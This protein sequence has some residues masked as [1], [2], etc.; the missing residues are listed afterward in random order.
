MKAASL[1]ILIIPILVL[2]CGHNQNI[3]PA[4]N[5]VLTEYQLYKMH[6]ETR[7]TRFIYS[8]GDIKEGLLLRWQGDSIFIQPRSYGST[9]YVPSRGLTA[10]RCEVGNR[11]YLGAAIGLLAGG[12]YFI[13]VEGWDF[14]STNSGKVLAK[15]LVP[16]VIALGAFAYGSSKI[17]TRTYIV[18]DGFRFDYRLAK[19][20]YKIQGE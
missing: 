6:Q 8:N 13:A 11:G 7:Q 2:S 14:Q 15:V 10:L 4:S 16:P 18:P 3:S 9:L 5:S 19:D 12:L 1:L 17:T 20:I